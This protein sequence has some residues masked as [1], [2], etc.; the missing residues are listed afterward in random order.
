MDA[1]SGEIPPGR[2]GALS[3]GASG[4]LKMKHL[5]DASS[6]ERPSSGRHARLTCLGRRVRIARI[7]RCACTRWRSALCASVRGRLQSL[8]RCRHRLPPNC[9]NAT[10]GPSL[11]SSARE[12]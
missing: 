7:A 6:L 10:R 4:S 2:N 1:R 8:A 9:E 12:Q 5:R 3:T 11:D